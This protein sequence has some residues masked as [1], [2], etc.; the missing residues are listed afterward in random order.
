MSAAQILGAALLALPFVVIFCLTAKDLGIRAAVAIFALTAVIV[1]V[2]IL[3]TW[4]LV[5]GS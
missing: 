5:E 2:V 3:G 1:G 4:L